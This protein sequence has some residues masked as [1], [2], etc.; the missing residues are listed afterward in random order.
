MNGYYTLRQAAEVL[1]I[2]RATLRRWLRELQID[3][4]QLRRGS[5]FLLSSELLDRVLDQH[6]PMR[7]S[8]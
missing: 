2:S 8:A 5:K 4:P 1:G 7:R 3:L 6:R